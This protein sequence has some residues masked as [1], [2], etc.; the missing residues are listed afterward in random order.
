MTSGYTEEGQN[1]FDGVPGDTLDLGILEVP[2]KDA[3]RPCCSYY[4]TAYGQAAEREK[5]AG[6][7]SIEHVYRFLSRLCSFYHKYGN[8]EIPYGPCC[9]IEG[10]RGY[11]PEDL[12]AKDL[13]VVRR[14]FTAVQDPALKARLGDIL[15][16]RCKDHQAAAVA[17]ESFVASGT[18]LINGEHW[19]EAMND[20]TRALQLVSIL[21]RE[22]PLWQ[23]T[24]DAVQRIAL[25]IPNGDTSFKACRIMNILLD[26]GA[27]DAKQFV[28]RG[29]ARAEAAAAIG[30]H[31]MAEGYWELEAR[32]RQIAK[33]EDGAKAA[34]L[35]A[36]ES[37]V[38]QAEAL[39]PKPA[40]GHLAASTLLA[41][42]V[43]ALRKAGAE[44][45]RVA[46]VKAK[47]LEYQK[48]SMGEMKEI[49]H[50]V[51][52]SKIIKSAEEHVTCD[53]FQEAVRRFVM[54]H[55]LADPVKLRQQVLDLAQKH[56]FSSIFGAT[57]VD[58]NGRAK[59]RTKGML[60][61]AEDDREA[62][63]EA[64]MF[65]H[66]AQFVWNFRAQAYIEPCRLKI[67]NMHHPTGQDISY[68]IQA[69]PFIPEG[70]E[71]IFARGLMAGFDG[72]YL[73]ASHFLVPQIE[74][75]LRY[76]LEQQGVDVTNLKSDMTQPLKLLG[77]LLGAPETKQIF[78]EPTV[79]EL[80]GLLIEK[81]GFGFRDQLAHGFVT[82]AECHSVPVV[83]IW[84]LVLR[85]CV[86][87]FLLVHGGGRKTY[88]RP[89][90]AATAVEAS[91]V[92]E[93]SQKKECGK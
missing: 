79:F 26:A 58:W 49:R 45:E 81:T 42:A 11:V 88:S 83:N 41:Q 25:A 30:N 61:L 48:K 84:W 20:F 55:P 17:S 63:I 78:G 89:K 50:Q 87:G 31:H 72:D 34:R 22:K 1:V 70:H 44:P 57:Y 85:L 40:S 77:P 92:S 7:P 65:Q 51:D 64:R 27:G 16:V 15:W 4:H 69:N 2:L 10:R 52:I 29:A 36:A 53:N 74:N 59:A 66:A 12:S 75:S 21:G 8:R 43:D 33:D 67:W 9:V 62:E 56:P 47:L 68:L 91:R 46:E 35:N 6:N 90:V 71:P 13:D 86:T 38:Q 32:C 18:C 80:R 37:K 73:M 19:M 3:K 93:A 28:G 23:T 24:S 76:V 82:A 5:E 54:G 60:N 14:L 39:V